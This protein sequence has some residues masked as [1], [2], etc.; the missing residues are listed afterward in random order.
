M[1]EPCPLATWPAVPASYILASD[2]RTIN[3]VWQRKASREWLGVNAIELPGGHCP[4]VS[5][6]EVLADTLERCA[7]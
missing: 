6:P 3:P 1:E 7:G 2:D 4:N 5:R